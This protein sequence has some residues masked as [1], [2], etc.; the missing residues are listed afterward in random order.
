VVATDVFTREVALEPVKDKSAATVARAM[1]NVLHDLHV[2]DDD[3]RR[4]AL[5]RTDQGKEFT[6]V[7]QAS[8]DIHQQ[9]DVRDTNGLAI[10]DRAI[11]SIK[12]DL[13][14][15]VGKK[16]GTKWTDVVQKVVDDH[17][18]KPQSAVFGP[19]DEVRA[20]P[21]QEFKVLQKNA[22]NYEVDRKN[23][24]RMK[25]AVRKAEFVRE[26][27]DNGGKSF[28]PSYGPAMAVENVDS[29]Y[30]YHKGFLKEL[31]AGRT[32]EDYKTLLKQAK[33]A[34]V[35]QLQGK[36]TLDTDKIHKPQAKTVMK[37]QA[38]SLENLL[39][40]EGSVSVEDLTKRV[41][42]LKRMT[43]RYKNLTESNWITRAFKDKFTVQ[44]GI[45]RLKNAPSSSSAAPTSCPRT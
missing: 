42:G 5:I 38:Q 28:K 6:S 26:P 40:K 14:A 21:I 36:L 23:T 20:N 4:P 16:R 11:Q 17:N 10:V 12:R 41:T 18:E 39:L 2:Y 31:Q 37:N 7:A 9:R 32:G 8:Q 3:E 30:V 43:K 25:D 24:D 27:I 35:G 19:P 44:D 22:E 45:A 29:E 13:A 15:E 33:P 1:R 34:T